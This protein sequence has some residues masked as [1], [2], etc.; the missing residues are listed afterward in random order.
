MADLATMPRVPAVPAVGTGRRAAWL[1]Y[2]GFYLCS[3]AV[4]GVY[5]QFLPVWLHVEQG[6]DE[7]HIAVILSAQTIS[8]TIAGPLWSQRVD[9]FGDPRRILGWLA[10]G[11][12]LAFTLFALAST[13]LS[14]FAVAFLF[15]CLY[16]PMHPIADAAAVRAAAAAGFSFGRL[17][18][19]GSGSFLVV[20]LL[21]GLW[22]ERAGAGLVFPI[23]VALLSATAVAAWFVPRGERVRPAAPGERAPLAA[24]FRSGPFVLLLVA[25]AMIQGSHAAYYQ[26]STVHW[27]AHGIEEGAAAALWAE[28]VLAEIALLFGAQRLLGRLRPTTLLSLGALGAAVRWSI[29]ASTT[30]LPVLFASN[31]LH[32][33]SFAAT[34]LGAIRAVEKRV[35]VGRRATAQGLVGA[36][37]SGG[38]MVLGGLVG[39]YAYDACGGGAFWFMAGFAGLGFGLVL[40]LRGYR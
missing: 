15:G 29:L 12:L 19:V 31:W 38:G 28:G 23:L 36:A 8:R 17:R 20:I 27:T 6:F 32:A 35:P 3:F 9:Q 13:L 18:V 21:A 34:Y 10:A 24:L 22:I 2:A 40:W 33:L 30:S 14:A 25:A 37:T 11:A 16:P 39:G 26:L 7:K 5:L 4:L 1:G